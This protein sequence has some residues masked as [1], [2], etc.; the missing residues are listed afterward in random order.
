MLPPVSGRSNLTQRPRDR[1]GESAIPASSGRGPP[2][3][4][5]SRTATAGESSSPLSRGKNANFPSRGVPTV[6]VNPPSAPWQ[7]RA[8]GEGIPGFRTSFDISGKGGGAFKS[9][10]E[11]FQVNPANGTM[12]F[13]LP[14]R[15]TPSRG[16]CG[17]ELML[18][19]DSGS[20]NGPFGLGWSV[21]L[22]SISRKTSRGIPRY[23]DAEDDLVMS[24][25]DIVRKLNDDGSVERRVESSAWGKF[26][27]TVYRPRVDDGSKRIEQW[28]NSTDL[29]DVHWRTISSSNETVIYGDTDDS[30][31]VDHSHPGCPR[32]IFSWLLSRS[33]DMFGNAIEY[34]YKR[35]DDKGVAGP[36]GMWPVWEA[37]RP[38]EPRVRQRYL[39][40][41]KYGN[42]TPNRHL[43]TWAASPSKWPE[44]WMFELV[45]DYGDHDQA[46]PNTNESRDWPVRED[47]FS[48][49]SAG[50]EVRTYRL[51]RRFLMFHHFPDKLNMPE[52]MVYSVTMQ[53]DESHQR[54]VLNSVSAA[55]HSLDTD[56]NDGTYRSKKMPPWSFFYTAV[57]E[58][59]SLAALEPNVI[60]LLDLPN[61]ESKVSEWL[62]L[63]SEGMPGLLTTGHDGT[64]L[65]Q[66]NRGPDLPP[67]EPQFCAPV[68]LARQPSLT[69]GT[70]QD[71][72]QTG[73]VNYV[74][75]DSQGA[76]QG[77]FQRGDSDTWSSYST[78]AETL[79]GDTWQDTVEIDL[80]GD[81]LADTLS[82][83]DDAQ[84]LLWQQNLGKQGFSGPKRVQQWAAADPRSRPR[85]TQ[86]ADVKIQV[87][88]MTGSGMA[89]LVEVSATSVRYWPNLGHGFFGTAIEMGNSPVLSPK[90]TFDHARVRFVDADGSGITDLLYLSPS[91]GATLYY[92]LS[93]NSWSDAIPIPNIPPTVMPSSV[94]TLDILGKGT[95]CL[96][97]SDDSNGSN[98]IK[99]LDLM[100]NTKPHLLAS[101]SNGLGAS[102]SI[103]YAPS[104]KFY[105]DDERDGKPWST[106]LPF[107]TQC[108]SHV[109]VRDA[110]TGSIQATD[111]VY[112]NGTYDF[113]EKQFSGFEMVD[114]FQS[115]SILIGK[116]G[117][118]Y[119]PPVSHTKLWFNVGLGLEVDQSRFLTKPVV[120]SKLHDDTT[121]IDEENDCADR[122]QALRGASLRSET[123]SRDGTT[124]ADVPFAIQEMSYDI[125]L[126]QAKGSNKYSVV[127]VNPREILAKQYERDMLDPRVTH[128]IIIKT[129]SFCD[130]EE[131][132]QIVYPR[133]SGTTAFADVNENQMA[134][135]MDFKQTWYTEPVIGP[136]DFRKPVAWRQREHEILRFP[137][138]AN[139]AIL[140]VD[141]AREF[142]FSQ[143][144]VQVAPSKDGDGSGTVTSKVLRNEIKAFFKDSRLDNRLGEGK[145]EAY[146]VLDQS[147]SLAYTDEI[148]KRV[149]RGLQNCNVVRKVE[150]LMVEGKYVKLEDSEGWWAPSSR[151]CFSHPSKDMVLGN[152]LKSAR[153]AFYNPSFFVDVFGNVSQIKMDGDFLLAEQVQDAVGN[154]STFQNDYQHL[155]PVKITDCN[156][157]AVQAMLDPLGHQIAVAVLGK[158]R[159]SN[160]DAD[161]RDDEADSL[162]DLP[163]E[164]THEDVKSLLSDPT[165]DL[166]RQI[167]GNAGSRTIY[168]IDWYFRSSSDDSK[169]STL[170]PA[171]DAL[172]TP[173][174]TMTM[175]RNIPFRKSRAAEIRLVISYMDGFGSPFQEV[176]LHDP[177]STDKKWLIPGLDVTNANGQVAYSFQ[178]RFSV[179]ATPI[180]AA[181]M[182]TPAAF[183][184][185]DTLGRG[186]AAMAADG[187]WSK[188]IHTPWATVEYNAGDTV[189]WSKPQQDLDVGHFFARL[190]AGLQPAQGWYDERLAAGTPRMRRAAEKS[191]IY[192]DA[193]V[194]THLGSCGLP[195]RTVRVASGETYTRSFVYD[196]NGNRIRDFDSYDR[197]VEK[198]VYDKLNRPIQSKGMDRGESWTI[199]DALD[200]ELLSW[201]C[202]GHSFLTLYDG[203]R[204]E[205]EK[206][207]TLD[208]SGAE[209]QLV[210][211]ITYGE[212][213]SNATALNLNNQV[214][215][216]EDQAGIHNS[217]KYDIRGRCVETTFQ[218]AR[219]YKTLV[220]WKVENEL[221]EPVYSHMYSYDV[222]GALLEERDA[223]G[224]RTRRRFTRQGLVE[225]VD[226]S[227]SGDQVWKPFLAGTTF[228]ADGLPETMTYGNKAVTTFSYDTASRQLVSQRTTRPTSRG[229]RELLEDLAHVYDC[230]GRRVGTLDG[231]EQV[232]Y[233]RGSVV[234]PEWDYTYDAAGRLVVA[235][236][237]AQ[238][239]TRPGSANKLQPY[240]AMTGIGQ[241]RGLANGNMVYRY[242]EKYDY[243]KEGN[244]K[245]MR[246]TA[247]DIK[248]LDGWTRSYFYEE[249]SL[250]SDDPRVKSNRLSRTAIGDQAEGNY[251]YSG[252]AGLAGCMTTVPKFTEL[253]WNM[254]NMLWFSSTQYMNEGTPERTYYVYDHAGNRVR[255]VTESSAISGEPA[256][257]QKDTLFLGGV[258]LLTRSDGS[259]L[260]T[261]RID[262]DN[263]LGV[264]ELHLNSTKAPEETS[265][266]LRPLVR[267]RVGEAMELDDSGQLVSYEEYSPFGSVVYSAM[268]GDVEA[269]RKYRFAM[270]EQDRETG[271]YH[272]GVRYYCPWLGRWT[273]PD[274]LGDVDGPNLYEYVKG[275]PVEMNDPEGTSSTDKY[276]A[277]KAAK[278][279]IAKKDPNDAPPVQRGKRAMAK[280]RAFFKKTGAFLKNTFK[281]VQQLYKKG[282]NAAKRNQKERDKLLATLKNIPREP[283]QKAGQ[284]HHLYK[285]SFGHFFMFAKIDHN[286]ETLHVDANVHNQIGPIH[287]KN[288]EQF[289]VQKLKALGREEGQTWPDQYRQSLKTLKTSELVSELNN[290]YSFYSEKLIEDIKSDPESWQS[291]MMQLQAENLKITG[292]DANSIQPHKYQVPYAQ[293][294]ELLDYP[295]YL[296]IVDRQIGALERPSKK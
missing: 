169:P 277:G 103:A 233:F 128:E 12:S 223:Q 275:D 285:N 119:E 212:R 219:E 14:I 184:S 1:Q 3:L 96:C 164:V 240:T 282:F 194:T 293:R 272:C 91:G 224:N 162:Q 202:R 107:P 179:S 95:G 267:V 221:E 166:G 137:F 196:V 236:G 171:D 261:A 168:C 42:R 6:P 181:A 69:G 161:V 15:T 97:W 120:Y 60:N 258:D 242:I 172:A 192:A 100:G 73:H 269:P 87:A 257:K 217:T 108:V 110:I 133:I 243:D 256:R 44:N 295:G 4:S 187:T 238:I 125:K 2:G 67:G 80:T 32:R 227:S 104:T 33:Y 230:V 83:V 278:K 127:Q 234:K 105:V 41:V 201:N 153:R 154:V 76:L 134:G 159:L 259:K 232:K 262:G 131:S 177:A 273:S 205:V 77:Y 65:Y 50:F 286:L 145:F 220:D 185:Y 284:Q 174:F 231:S 197:L 244:I 112:H 26:E 250:L 279:K 178:P 247:P 266:Q 294:G 198:T 199:Y 79:A 62:D 22:P 152:E 276:K 255:K 81:G 40:R 151:A 182:N 226:F 101:Y 10:S 260:W 222:F 55:G 63:D 49:S 71:L 158:Q 24:G 123:Y 43:D 23:L 189:L 296:D 30:R 29:T 245:H 144:P 90:E 265:Q 163:V 176:H 5:G 18:S 115:E 190:P 124:K 56:K 82:M 188:T 263:I 225:A 147:Y 157:N 175:T 207:V 148:L 93:G 193:P 37:N 246:H 283:P 35:E 149:E 239:S 75:R 140:S 109:E 200:D 53:Y 167:L 74:L 84:S 249:Q 39:K 8:I 116:E 142:A 235:T 27:V 268:Y 215:K 94:F 85:L 264:V 13:S 170:L 237:R 58:P 99:Y 88:D 54:T 17:P 47:P 209:S 204:R 11:N 289:F 118:T 271:L 121:D 141:A 45:L 25:A 92:N 183:A 191:V 210:T 28:A 21:S 48:Q 252:S 132:L 46:C 214:W 251:A 292:L 19:Y 253:D 150:D 117:E 203:I 228:T 86:S 165:G 270:Y 57:T 248:G 208:N 20:G 122:L 70:F 180:R 106:R 114:T 36:D 66:R 102:T 64:F 288:W 274:P 211:R 160:A 111:Y 52:N 213:C 34:T 186:V 139:G 229:T 206:L 126:L 72:D 59:S 135:N 216:I 38:P 173:A 31:I 254:N 9:I 195:V 136:Y 98:R 138:H 143:L 281:T 291:N 16:G 78:F 155:Q 287:D 241:T 130:V 129:N 290:P 7:P 156:H 113:V 218:A 280:I 146:S 51:C 61:S 89:D 68:A